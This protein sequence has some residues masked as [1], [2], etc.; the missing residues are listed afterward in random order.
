M[1]E[2]KTGSGLKVLL[3]TVLFT[4]FLGLTASA[5]QRTYVNFKSQGSGVYSATATFAREQSAYSKINVTKA[6][7][8]NITGMKIDVETNSHSPLLV[9]LYDSKFKKLEASSSRVD[10]DHGVF[11]AYGVKKGTYYIR[12][13]NVRR[14]VLTLQYKPLTEKSGKT[15]T[16]AVTLP[17]KKTVKGLAAAGEKATTADW[18]RFQVTQKQV[19][20]LILAADG[21][22]NLAFYLYGPSY[23]DGKRVASL[24]KAQ[25]VFYS[26]NAL[27]QQKTAVKPGMY[28]LKVIRASNSRMASGSY[29]L[30]WNLV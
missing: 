15:K 26:I 6:G 18:Y 17:R 30:Y 21:N 29:S 23:P 12:V 5:A 27:T 4:A 19:L 9:S 2:K 25:N 1:R 3:F 28:Y 13:S 20:K 11:A 16:A 10:G 7:V 24:K 22:G 14:Y 8:F